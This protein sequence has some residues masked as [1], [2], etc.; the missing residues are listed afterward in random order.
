MAARAF[1]RVVP[2]GNQNET[3]DATFLKTRVGRQG[4]P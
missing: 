1:S 3:V 2:S 4:E